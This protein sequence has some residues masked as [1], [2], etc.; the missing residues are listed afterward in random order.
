MNQ[1][2]STAA[3]PSS[4]RPW[5][6]EAGA[7]LPS[8]LHVFSGQLSEKEMER[9]DERGRR[10]GS[11][12]PAASSGHTVP[13]PGSESLQ[14]A[15]NMALHRSHASSGPTAQPHCQNRVPGHVERVMRN[16]AHPPWRPLSGCW[17]SRPP[18]GSP[19]CPI[20][21]GSSHCGKRSGNPLLSGAQ[22]GFSQNICQA[23]ALLATPCWLLGHS[24]VGGRRGPSLQK[25]MVPSGRQMLDLQG[26]RSTDGCIH[27][28]FSSYIC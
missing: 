4:P 7:C 8:T 25:M 23:T 26:Q 16:S 9:E 22:P 20:A 5:L 6:G 18:S 1:K 11:T 12:F 14:K 3:V 24:S 28:L 15:W 21:P 19:C 2:T 10:G 13:F 17:A 27:N